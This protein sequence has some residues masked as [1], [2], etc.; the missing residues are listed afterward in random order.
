MI[1]YLRGKVA[2]I[3]RGRLVVMT[4]G[5]G[6]AVQVSSNL[7]MKQKAGNEVELYI[8]TQVREDALNLIGFEKLEELQLFEQLIGVSGVGPKLG[9]AII[10]SDKSDVVIRAIQEG[11]IDFFTA[12]SGIGKKSAQRLI[13]E[14]QNSVGGEDLDLSETTERKEVVDAIASLGFAKKEVREALKSVDLDLDV[15]DQIKMGLKNLK[16]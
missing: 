10:E 15:E 16:K 6:Y 5:V 13:V 12:I 11:D 2:H 7:L 4:N 14:L 1:G 9:L 3:D 8:Y